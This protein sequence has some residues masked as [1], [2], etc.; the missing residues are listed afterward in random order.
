VSL[1]VLVSNPLEFWVL[2]TF[3][4]QNCICHFHNWSSLLPP[5]TLAHICAYG[6]SKYSIDLMILL[7]HSL[8]QGLCVVTEKKRER[9]NKRS[10]C[11]SK[12]ILLLKK[13][14]LLLEQKTKKERRKVNI[15]AAVLSL[16]CLFCVTRFVSRL[17]SL[18][19]VYPR[20]STVLSLNA[21]LTCFWLTWF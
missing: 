11:S 18:I 1:L 4:H 10:S 5:K 8:I 6:C 16:F 7:F 17:T 20:T 14:I 15:S 12:K 3:C 19:K 13:K 2:V 9:K 21:S